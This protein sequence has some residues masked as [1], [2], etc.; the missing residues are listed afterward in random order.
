MSFLVDMM[1]PMTAISGPPP[2]P[3]P[4]RRTNCAVNGTRNKV[5]IKTEDDH[6]P[7]PDLDEDAAARMRLKRKLQRN[8]TSF[9]QAQIEN[10]EREF[11]KTHYP[12]VFAREN[13]ASRINLPEARIQVWFSNRR[14][15]FRRETKARDQKRACGEGA[16]IIQQHNG[17]PTPSSSVSSSGSAVSNG[18][19]TSSSNG[20]IGHGCGGVL[21]PQHPTM[22]NGVNGTNP[23][24][25]QAVT[26]T[27]LLS[28]GD[29]VNSAIAAISATN[30]S[31]NGL[32][33]NGSNNGST[34]VSPAATPTA[35]YPHQAMPPTGFMQPGA[36]MYTNLPHTMDPYGFSM[37]HAQQDFSSYHMFNSGRY[38]AF[39]PY[40]RTMHPAQQAFSTSM[41]H[42][43]IPNGGVPGL[44]AG[45]SLQV[46][47]LSGIDQSALGAP[48]THLH[49]LSDV[50]HDPS[51]LYWRQ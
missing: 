6:K 36:H 24:I 5:I 23:S 42:N 2:P 11:E 9:T 29:S 47:V 27:P 18:S 25:P 31:S 20:S 37:G 1:Q 39:N 43:S 17:I 35:R 7:S 26:S 44:S 49:D 51:A 4:S 28:N 16:Q 12:D 8:R 34:G 3:P 10:L 13:L 41:N 46:S 50:H 48:T 45:M 40:A 14:A 19:A 22:I 15:K 38:E 21:S 33:T 32:S 30:S